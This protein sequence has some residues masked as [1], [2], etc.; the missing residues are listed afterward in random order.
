MYQFTEDCMIGI[1][2]IDEEH[3]QL[4]QMINEAT[5]LAQGGGDAG[6]VGS[7]L[8]RKL[9]EYAQTHF[10][11]EESYMEQINDTELAV[12][13]REHTAFVEK[14]DSYADTDWSAA[15]SAQ[16]LNELLVFMA[17]WLYCHILGSD[18]MIGKIKQTEQVSA[19]DEI[20]FTDEYRTGI[21]LIDAEHA[22]LFEIIRETKEVISAQFLHDKYDEIV[23]ILNELREYTILHFRDEENYMEQIGYEGLALQCAAHTAFVDRLNEINPDDVD[24]NQKEYLDELLEFLL[25][26][27]TNHILKMDKQIPAQ[28]VEK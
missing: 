12:Q 5:A 22:R 14:I 3:R 26:W 7:S 20:V 21:E 9:K 25:K 23:Q 24:D 18:I 1:A 11:H 13:K 27:L 28:A 16:V 19:S 4:F 2:Q 10:A 8:L 17:R 15:G 6:T